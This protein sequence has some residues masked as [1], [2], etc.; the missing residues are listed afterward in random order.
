LRGVH[1]S[2]TDLSQPGAATSTEVLGRE[3]GPYT[4]RVDVEGFEWDSAL[5]APDGRRDYGELRYTAFGLIGD[6]LFNL[7][8]TPRA[9]RVRVISLRRANRRE[10]RRYVE[11]TQDQDA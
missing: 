7:V 5:I 11:Q 3:N 2:D 6:C 4:D 10:V 1:E 8:F 9:G